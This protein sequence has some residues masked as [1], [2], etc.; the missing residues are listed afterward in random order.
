MDEQTQIL[1]GIGGLAITAIGGWWLKNRGKAV[2]KIADALEDVVED[3]TGKDIELDEVVSDVLNS[4]EDVV[5]TAAEDAMEAAEEGESI[6]EALEGV[7]E[8]VV[9]D[10]ADSLDDLKTRLSD[11][12]VAELKALLKSANLHVSGN[13]LQLIDRLTKGLDA[14]QLSD[15]I[16]GE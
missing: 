11:M 15:V 5:E 10:L 7:A 16:G 3:L 13:K 6:T 4:V 9:E 12:K 2:S 1:I 8:D 14:K